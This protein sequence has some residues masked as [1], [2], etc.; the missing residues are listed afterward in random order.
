MNYKYV[1]KRQSFII[2]IS[3]LIM[4]VFLIGT[5]YALFN[6]LD[7]SDNN[8][9]VTLGTL[10]INYSTASTTA[11]GNINPTSEENAT[12]YNINLQNN[13]TLP[14]EYN[15]IVYTDSDNEVS[16]DLIKVKLDEDAE[17]YLSE[18]EKIDETKTGN[19]SRYIIGTDTIAEKNASGD[20][21]N[22]IIKTWIDDTLA[23][24]TINNKKI[25]VKVKIEGIVAGSEKNGYYYWKESNTYANT[26]APT[27]V[28]NNYSSLVTTGVISALLRTKFV[29]DTPVLHA[30]CLYYN[31]NLFCID[32]DYWKSIVDST[33]SN[34]TNGSIVK[35]ALER[36]MGKAL[37][38]RRT[39]CNSGPG[40][41][42]CHF[43]SS[44]CSSK[45]NGNVYCGISTDKCDVSEAGSAHCNE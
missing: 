28:T 18:L 15:I 10:I 8:Q 36:D 39:S 4:T 45:P 24:N 5:T 20:S 3:I 21:K 22:Y 34:S 12:G 6:Q 16:H 13:G 19:E 23:D 29:N 41:A 31:D 7:K 17:V 40:I 30:A 42:S 44:Y 26:I 1:I 11:Q 37:G 35:K 14:M 43:G 25:S 33:E 9:V 27:T 2:T 38:V 32:Y